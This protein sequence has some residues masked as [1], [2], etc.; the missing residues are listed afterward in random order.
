MKSVLITMLLAI[1]LCEGD[2][3]KVVREI[4]KNANI[5]DPHGTLK[6]IANSDMPALVAYTAWGALK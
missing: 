4:A 3:N 5:F 1:N 6:V 2:P